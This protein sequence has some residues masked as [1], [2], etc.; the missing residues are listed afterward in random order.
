MDG[1]WANNPAGAELRF[2]KSGGEWMEPD[3]RDSLPDYPIG[4]FDGRTGFCGKVGGGQEEVG[5]K[6]PMGG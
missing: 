2:D 5:G 6:D 3:R 4:A 1:W